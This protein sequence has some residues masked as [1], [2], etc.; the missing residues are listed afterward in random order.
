MDT[1]LLV[2]IIMVHLGIIALFYYLF[3]VTKPH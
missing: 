2:Y 3:N 1:V